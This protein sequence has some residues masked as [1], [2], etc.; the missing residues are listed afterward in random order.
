MGVQCLYIKGPELLLWAGSR[1][2]SGKI[3]IDG[4]FNRLNYFVLFTVFS[5]DLILRKKLIKCYMSSI[6]LYCTETWNVVRT[7]KR[8]KD[9]WI[10]QNWRKNCLL[11]HV[12]EGNVEARIEVT[13]R[14]R[15]RCK[16]LLDKLMETKEY[17]KLKA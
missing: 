10:G 16:Q 13:G 2:A 8:I 4:V 7:V 5:L 15:R 11:K 9:I 14:R 6:T 3:S 12:I 1:T 17:L